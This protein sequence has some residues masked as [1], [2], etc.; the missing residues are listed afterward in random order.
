MEDYQKEYLNKLEPRIEALA[1]AETALTAGNMEAEASARRIAHTLRGSGGTFG[2]PEITRLAEAVE[3]A[4]PG[5]LQRSLTELIQYLRSLKPDT[6]TAADSILIIDDSE[7]M[8]LI[9][10]TILKRQNYQI[11]QAESAAQ[12]REIL[13]GQQ[14][15]LILLDLVLPDT[16][17]RNFLIELKEDLATTSIPVIVLSAKSS[18]QIKAECYALGA[19]NYFEKPVDP[20]L[21]TTKVAAT[22]QTSKNLQKD[23]RDDLLT[24]LLNRAAFR[25]QFDQE[26]EAA[27]KRRTAS[28]LAVLDLDHFKMVN[29]H[30]GHLAGDAVLK[31]VARMIKQ[32][33]RPADLFGRWGGEEFLV[34]QSSAWSWRWTP[35]R[36]RC[37][38][39]NSLT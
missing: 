15:A 10:G 4:V 25:R 16:D 27:A 28:S 23:L 2:F 34:L 19:E 39:G 20:A 1:A 11:L 24:G 36:A 22:L 38:G 6:G 9:L 26:M 12:A 8:L 21:L 30:Y 14:V 33:L 17:G 5:D 7:E 18:S 32:Y 3:E 35:K 31:Y 37:C 29:D 13:A